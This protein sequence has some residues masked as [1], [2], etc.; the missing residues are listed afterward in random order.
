MI[1]S[2]TAAERLL[3]ADD[4]HRG[5][6]DVGEDAALECDRR[7]ALSPPPSDDDD[8]TVDED[9]DAKVWC[10]PSPRH[11]GNLQVT[12]TTT[13]LGGRDGSASAACPG[14]PEDLRR[15]RRDVRERRSKG[16]LSPSASGVI[17][18]TSPKNNHFSIDSILGRRVLSPSRGCSDGSEASEASAADVEPFGDS[19]DEAELDAELDAEPLPRPRTPAG[20]APSPPPTPGDEQRGELWRAFHGA[21]D[22][23]QQR[24]V[25]PSPVHGLPALPVPALLRMHGMQHLH[26]LGLS[27]GLPPGLSALADLNSLGLGLSAG[28]PAGLSIHGLGALGVHI[29]GPS[30]PPDSARQLS[31]AGTSA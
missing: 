6:R 25:R 29:R 8:V 9:D 21:D 4:V 16:R 31:D 1:T 13:E 18:S 3:L 7:S 15:D 2:V 5:H 10:S 14:S 24:F 27:A 28:L 23:E 11:C 22:G 20:L 12:S 26:G 17:S 19:G 30:L